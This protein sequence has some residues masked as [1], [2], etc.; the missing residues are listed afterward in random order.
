MNLD[1]DMPFIFAEV[2][3]DR[4]TWIYDARSNVQKKNS[5]DTDTIGRY[6]STKAVGSYS[7]M[8]VTEKYKYP[9]GRRGA[10]GPCHS[11]PRGGKTDFRVGKG[12][13]T[14][15]SHILSQFCLNGRTAPWHLTPRSP[16]CLQW[17]QNLLRQT[18]A[19][20]SL[21]QGTGSSHSSS[22][23]AVSLGQLHE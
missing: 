5:S 15:S 9:E 17:G 18:G 19:S 7:R 11:G 6:I 13:A 16:G 23:R 3:A 4:I 21:P 14:C 12:N 20:R 10:A 1:F 8:D 2:N 22:S